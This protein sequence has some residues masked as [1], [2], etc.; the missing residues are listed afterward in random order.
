[1]TCAR[2]ALHVGQAVLSAYRSQFSKHRFPQPQLL[3]IWCLR[4]YEDWTFREAEVRLAEHR[5]LRAALGLTQ[6]PD[7]TTLDRCLCRRDDAVLEPVLTA[8]V[9]Q[10]PAPPEESC[11]AVAVEA[12]GL[13]PG[14]ISTCVVKRA[15]D[16][17]EGF[18]WRHWLT[19]TVAVDS[20]RRR[21]VAQVAR[22][23]PYNDGATLRP[24]GE[25]ARQRVPVAQ[26]AALRPG[27][28]TLSPHAAPAGAVAGLS[29]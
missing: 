11:P 20:G 21:V 22:R 5:D 19:W 14:A 24:L 9:R 1:V 28:R 3:A 25:A 27:S 7:C 8:A 6:A 2:V 4:R 16:H 13:A 12:T 18:T 17:G 29:L 26:T 23:G 15:K 10:L